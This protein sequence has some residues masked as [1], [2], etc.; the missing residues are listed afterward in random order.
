MATAKYIQ[1]GQTIDY[2]PK[3]NIGYLDVVPFAACIGVAAE[4]IEAGK[5]GAVSLVGVYELPAATGLAITTGD[6][7]YWSKSDNVINKTAEGGVPA[8]LCI[9][10]KA[11]AATTVL[12]K[13]G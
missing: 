9:A 4:A 2:T 13:I 10:D 6:A 11:D 5:T 12:V 3:S 7:V 1:K 8:G